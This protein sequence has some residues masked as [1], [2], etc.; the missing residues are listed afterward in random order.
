MRQARVNVRFVGRANAGS[1]RGL[2]VRSVLGDTR[3]RKSRIC[4]FGR[5]HSDTLHQMLNAA[6][7]HVELTTMKPSTTSAYMSSWPHENTPTKRTAPVLLS[8]L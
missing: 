8:I 1:R 2:L 3:S 5:H 4:K 7:L 6:V